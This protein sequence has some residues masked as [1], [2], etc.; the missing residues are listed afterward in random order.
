[1]FWKKIDDKTILDAMDPWILACAVG[2]DTSQLGV[3]MTFD[4]WLARSRG[5]WMPRVASKTG[6]GE[7]RIENALRAFVSKHRGHPYR[8]I[9]AKLSEDRGLRAPVVVE[10]GQTIQLVSQQ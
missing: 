7:R 2:A 9:L 5:N 6:A 1:M 8:V 3:P 4:S 10:P